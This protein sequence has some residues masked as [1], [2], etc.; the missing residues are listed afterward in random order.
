[1]QK[2][3]TRTASIVAFA[4]LLIT[5]PAQSQ[6]PQG[7]GQTQPQAL[8]LS[9]EQIAS[10]AQAYVEIQ[11]LRQQYQNE[12][13]SLSDVDSSRAAE[14]QSQFRQDTQ[15]A[16]QDAGIDQQKFSMIMQMVPAN[17]NI[18]EQFF[19]AIEE[20][21]GQPPEIPDQQQRG[22]RGQQQRQA[23]QVDVSDAELEKIAQAFVSIQDLRSE[24]QENHGSVQDSTK[25]QQLQ[26]E[27][28][29]EA[30]QA[31]Q[32]EDVSQQK[33]SQVLKAVRSDTELRERFFSAVEDAGGEIPAPSGRQGPQGQQGR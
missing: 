9:P 32:D 22:Q 3:L 25:M 29:S 15:Q 20:A 6:I 23:P 12:Y 28:R 13:G 16:M 21:G 10:A 7:Q 19:S 33:F 18:K 14:I 24:Y 26:Q 31:L 2:I 5:L 27:F 11:D 4:L 1:M 30:Q 17:D 8:Q